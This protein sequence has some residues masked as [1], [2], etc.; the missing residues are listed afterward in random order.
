MKCKEMLQ[1]VLQWYLYFGTK[2]FA[3]FSPE[4]SPESAAAAERRQRAELL[5]T[6]LAP[7]LEDFVYWFGRSRELLTA[8]QLDFLT[9]AAQQD[10]IRRL[11]QAES[12]V[13]TARLLY[14]A[15]GKQ[16]AI[17]MEPVREWHRLLMECQGIGMRYRF[18][19]R[20]SAYN[21]DNDDVEDAE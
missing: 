19:Q 14:Q 4:F 11:E 17:D 9:P 20:H 18:E 16:V 13:K 7:L 3:M 12:E 15:S 5:E 2:P 10:L 21:T 1:S 8:T 6:V